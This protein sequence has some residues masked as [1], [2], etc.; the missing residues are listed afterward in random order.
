MS[1]IVQI[2]DPVK[3]S[4]ALVTLPDAFLP[5]GGL[6]VLDDEES[7]GDN[8]VWPRK[9]IALWGGNRANVMANLPFVAVSIPRPNLIFLL[10]KAVNQKLLHK[11]DLVKVYSLQNKKVRAEHPFLDLADLKGL[12]RKGK[13]LFS[14]EELVAIANT[15][16]TVSPQDVA[17]FLSDKEHHDLL[18]TELIRVWAQD[19]ALGPLARAQILELMYRRQP[20]SLDQETLESV[21]RAAARIAPHSGAVQIVVQVMYDVER[22]RKHSKRDRSR[23]EF[24]AAIAQMIT[25]LLRHRQSVAF[26]QAQKLLGWYLT[27]PLFKQEDKD[28]VEAEVKRHTDKIARLYGEFISHA[29]SKSAFDAT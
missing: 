8:D 19:H 29:K 27:N 4:N 11:R 16:Q 24:A 1:S 20:K 9:I 21:L 26:F 14:G 10:Q 18:P 12:T 23:E 25:P 5:T 2:G 15:V 7:F 13:P 28:W 22:M 3:K 6:R 17:M